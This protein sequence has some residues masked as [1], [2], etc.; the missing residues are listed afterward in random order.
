MCV[1]LVLYSKVNV[2]SL[3]WDA[4]TNPAGN[5]FCTR[6]AELGSVH[7]AQRCIAPEKGRIWKFKNPNVRW[8]WRSTPRGVTGGSQGQGA[9][10]GWGGP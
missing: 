1:L 4:A 3:P 9:A 10:V 8:G 7:G 6:E 5:A 2:E